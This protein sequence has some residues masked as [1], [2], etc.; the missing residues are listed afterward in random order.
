M[1]LVGCVSEGADL[2]NLGYMDYVTTVRAGQGQPT[3]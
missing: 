2:G 1:G 3:T